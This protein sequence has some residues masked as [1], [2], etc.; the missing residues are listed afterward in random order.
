M[1]ERD[2]CAIVLAHADARARVPVVYPRRRGA[3]T[4]SRRVTRD[5]SDRRREDAGEHRGGSARAVRRGA[6]DAGDG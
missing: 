6:G 5:A 1:T 4:V 3:G 2:G